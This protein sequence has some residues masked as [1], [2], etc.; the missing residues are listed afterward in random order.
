[1]SLCICLSHSDVVSSPMATSGL[2]MTETPLCVAADAVLAHT[3][4]HRLSQRWESATVEVCYMIWVAGCV[5]YSTPVFSPNYRCDSE[6]C[7][8][9]S[10]LAC[11]FFLSRLLW[12][13]LLYIVVLY[14]LY[15]LHIFRYL[16]FVCL[17]QWQIVIKYVLLCHTH[18]ADQLTVCLHTRL[19]E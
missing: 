4:T 2:T 11:I 3:Q 12:K 16:T 8:Q 15:I 9:P 10:H 6:F 7:F 17:W 14:K 18:P 5:T 13:S 19:D 1:M